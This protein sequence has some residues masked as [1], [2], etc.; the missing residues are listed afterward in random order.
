MALVKVKNEDGDWINVLGAT[1]AADLKMVK[2]NPF[3]NSKI[4]GNDSAFDLSPYIGANDNFMIF[5]TTGSGIG[6]GNS[7]I[8]LVY[9]KSDGQLR[10]LHDSINIQMNTL[11]L[12]FHKTKQCEVSY[13]EETRIFDVVMQEPSDQVNDNAWLFYPAVKGAV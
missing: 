5:F 1:L 10:V 12:L 13:D 11:D 7:C 8:P 3:P 2:I 9:I 6:G 4:T